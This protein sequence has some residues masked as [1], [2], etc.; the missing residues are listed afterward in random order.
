MTD[1]DVA[2]LNE[3][4]EDSIEFSTEVTVTTNWCEHRCCGGGWTERPWPNQRYTGRVLSIAV[5]RFLLQ[6]RPDLGKIAEVIV[7][8]D[9]LVDVE[10][11]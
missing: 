7:P 5:E 3:L 8:F 6:V 2:E 10:R 4:L 11:S 9:Y 1:V